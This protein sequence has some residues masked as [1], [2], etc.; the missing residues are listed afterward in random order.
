M[1]MLCSPHNPLE[2]H[3]WLGLKFSLHGVRE[4]EWKWWSA[5]GII[6]DNRKIII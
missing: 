5:M 1:I 2:G 6:T 4:P 3:P